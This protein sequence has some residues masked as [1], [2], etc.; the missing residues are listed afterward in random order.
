MQK[1]NELLKDRRSWKELWD[2]VL[3]ILD[4]AEHAGDG[5]LYA[6]GFRLLNKLTEVAAEEV[7]P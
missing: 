2:L 1:V 4:G 7:K 6:L 3:N 5:P